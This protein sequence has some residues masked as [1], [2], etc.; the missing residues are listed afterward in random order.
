MRRS[1]THGFGHFFKEEIVK[2]IL[3]TFSC[4]INSK[5]SLKSTLAKHGIA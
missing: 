3:Y 1:Q 5:Y 4:I 2:S